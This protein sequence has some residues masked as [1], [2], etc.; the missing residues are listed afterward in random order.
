MRIIG[1]SSAYDRFGASLLSEISDYLGPFLEPVS[2]T[3]LK[4][5]VNSCHH[6]EAAPRPA[7]DPLAER[8]AVRWSHLP[9]LRYRSKAS[10]IA[11]D[12]ASA[13]L[14][15]EA[16]GYGNSVDAKFPIL[17]D[18][19]ISALSEACSGSK[20]VSRDVDLA[21][22]AVALEQARQKAPR[23][24]HAIAKTLEAIR[25][26]RDAGRAEL[27]KTLDFDEV[28]WSSYPAAVRVLLN[29]PLYWNSFDDDAPHGND[30]GADLLRAFRIWRPRHRRDSA[31]EFLHGLLDKWD[32]RE[33]SNDDPDVE[34][35]V[36]E[37]EIAL[38][39][40]QIK[41]D[42]NCDFE[43]AAIALAAI[44][45]RLSD[46]ATDAVRSAQFHKLHAAI[47]ASRA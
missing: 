7:L 47:I 28:D 6:T 17:L 1:T 24:P 22:L 14:A 42:G 12:Y 15:E 19:L 39:F 5:E 9:L 31:V 25:A 27:L 41:T 29:D 34:Q 30:T 43:V 33:R 37:A 36:T 40:A 21:A 13:L 3:G 16:L 45:R 23:T 10:K 8:F 38:V 2:P 46:L 44:D 18:E 26:A 20:S 4:V 35:T 11:L 32:M